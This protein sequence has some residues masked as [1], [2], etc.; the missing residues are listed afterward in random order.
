VDRNIDLTGIDEGFCYEREGGPETC[1]YWRSGCDVDPNARFCSQ[2]TRAV[3]PNRH[4]LKVQTCP[5]PQEPAVDTF[6]GFELPELNKLPMGTWCGSIKDEDDC[7]E[8]V[9]QGDGEGSTTLYGRCVWDKGKCKKTRRPDYDEVYFCEE[10]CKDIAG[11]TV[12][13]T[14]IQCGRGDFF[15]EPEDR[16]FSSEV[17]ESYVSETVVPG[18]PSIL[19]PCVAQQP[20]GRGDVEQVCF[21][22]CNDNDPTQPCTESCNCVEP[23][24]VGKPGCAPT[25]KQCCNEQTASG[26]TCV[27]CAS[28]R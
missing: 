17:C 8:S 20:G 7:D 9:Y 13:G 28:L 15:R 19:M 25:E 24:R 4:K 14:D 18:E 10:T 6:C 12:L 22:D 27:D 5:S 2:Y 16:L 23:I 21:Q 26:Y 1:E 3:N 11:R